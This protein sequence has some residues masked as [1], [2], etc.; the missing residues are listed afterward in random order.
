MSLRISRCS[1]V[2]FTCLDGHANM[3]VDRAMF[4]MCESDPESAS[5]RF[6]TWAG[7]TLSMGHFEPQD[8]VDMAAARADGVPVVRRPTGGRVVLHGD[9]LTY[10]VVL[11]GDG[12]AAA[13]EIYR[14]VSQVLVGGLATLGARLD[15]KRGRTGRSSVLRKPCFASVSRHEVTHRGRKVVGSA[16][17]R[18]RRAVLQHGSIPLGPGY[19]DVVKYMKLAVPVR[20][21]LAREMAAG[22]ACLADVLGRVVD[23]AEVA[24]A[25]GSAFRS[26]LDCGCGDL[27]LEKIDAMVVGRGVHSSVTSSDKSP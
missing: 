3:A 11:P 27:P 12:H 2:E 25:L 15:I 8:A 7:P 22:T 14:L 9:D 17:R 20:R 18:G 23:P 10:T 26:E 6:Y 5:V 16:Q 4:D 13:Q 1:L 19:M 24:L 21:D